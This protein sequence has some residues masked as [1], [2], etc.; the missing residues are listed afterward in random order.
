LRLAVLGVLP[1]FARDAT[2]G[3]DYE[4]SVGGGSTDNLTRVA[5]E[6]AIDETIASA[7]LRLSFDE[8]NRRVDADVVADFDYYEYLDG[9]YDSEVIGSLIGNTRVALVDERLH[10]TLRDNFGQ[11]LIDPFSPASPANRENVNYLDTGLEST[12][13]F[14][15]QT[16]LNLGG[17]YAMA[18]YE[19]SPLDSDTVIGELALSRLPSDST[20]LGVHARFAQVGY[21]D[22]ALSAFDYDQ[23]ELFVRYNINGARTALNA[24]A[25][26]TRIERDDGTTENSP[27]VR[28][29]LQRR[30]TGMSMLRLQAGQEF[31]NSASA[32]AA[33]Q[34]GSVSLDTSAGRQTASPFKHRFADLAWLVSGRRTT[35]EISAGQRRQDYEDQPTLDQTLTSLRA[36]VSRSVSATFQVSLGASMDQ[37]E[38]ALA[39]SDYDDLIGNFSVSWQA[40]RRLGLVFNY[41][42]HDREQDGFGGGYTENRLWLSLTYRHGSPRESMR[43]VFTGGEE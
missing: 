11:V 3:W 21:S 15:S 39:G 27:L 10:W 41:D 9:D 4:A 22:A 28:I 33:G 38:F 24:A 31:S 19:D 34:G 26:Y 37:G 43:S 25:G 18:M 32:F 30:L 20:M 12:F 8:S 36:R 16:R 7:G 40:S 29:T 42:Y 14:G 5:D 1:L 2:A 35:L 13:S 23:S 6:D 17:A